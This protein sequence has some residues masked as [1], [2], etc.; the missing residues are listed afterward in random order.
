MGNNYSGGVI[1]SHGGV[2]KNYV[3]SMVLVMEFIFGKATDI[4]LLITLKMPYFSY[5]KFKVKNS[6]FSDISQYLLLNGE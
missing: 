2:L 5:L 6:I 3:L 4:Q 1:G